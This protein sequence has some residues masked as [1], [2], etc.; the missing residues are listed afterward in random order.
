LDPRAVVYPT[1]DWSVPERRAR[2]AFFEAAEQLLKGHPD[3]GVTF[4]SLDEEAAAFRGFL[5]ALAIGPYS[6][7]GTYAR[8]CG[9]IIWLEAGRMLHFAVAGH[10][11]G[12]EGI[13]N[14]TLAL[15]GG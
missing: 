2:R 13:I 5:A 12:S 7:G 9:S 4:Y 10:L 8:G 15:W 1:V 11:I 3:L 14:T 6:V